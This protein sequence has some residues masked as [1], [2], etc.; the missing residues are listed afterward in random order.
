ME[1]VYRD[2]SPRGVRFY[3]IYKALAHPE[4][5]GYVQPVSLEERLMHIREAKAKLGSRIPWLCDTM[6]N[7]A[8][9]ALGNA[10]N[11]EFII[12]PEGK[13]VV[14]RVWSR[15]DELRK[16]LEK[17][18]GKVDPPTRV[19]DLGIRPYFRKSTEDSSTKRL[20]LPANLRPLRVTTALSEDPY[21]VKLRA[22]VEP[23]VLQ[24]QAGQL[25][26]GFR[27]DPL[28]S[29]HWNNLAGPFE[30]EIRSAKGLVLK[31]SRGKGPKIESETDS[32]PREFLIQVA[33]KGKQKDRTFEVVVRYFACHDKEGWCRA[34]THTYTVQL[35]A[36]PD[37][38]RVMRGNRRRPG[39]PMAGPRGGRFR[40]PF[41]PGGDRVM[42]VITEG[43][44]T[45]GEIEPRTRSGATRTFRITD[46]TRIMRRGRGRPEP[47]Q[48][49]RLQQGMR[50]MLQP[51]KADDGEKPPVVRM[52]VM[53]GPS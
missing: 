41:A 46:A 48:R 19:E 26:L 28:Y 9:H 36:N 22:E 10:P 13:V 35:E 50:V 47:L 42:G 37:G 24:G 14:K 16:D 21:Y 3:F 34:F 17:L 51:G 7:D 43:D 11:S 12:D 25:Y 5:N 45:S 52:M 53:R 31:P 44:G 40:P 32:A 4:T 27:L 39:P 8:L 6:D 23:N 18:V 20:T 2:Y 1:T 30:F 49:E 29:V 38:G 33:P 15:P